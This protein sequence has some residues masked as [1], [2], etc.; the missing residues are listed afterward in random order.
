V[1]RTKQYN[2]DRDESLLY[3][4]TDPSKSTYGGQYTVDMDPAFV[5]RFNKAER[6]YFN[7]QEELEARFR[8]CQQKEKR[9]E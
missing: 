2:L 8:I 5:A 9:G 1:K 3:F 6:A 4:V 7:M